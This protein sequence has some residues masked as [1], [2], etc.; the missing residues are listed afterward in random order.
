MPYW[1]SQVI[2]VLCSLALH[3]VDSSSPWIIKDRIPREYNHHQLFPICYK[4]TSWLH[5]ELITALWEWANWKRP[6]VGWFVVT[7]CCGEWKWIELLKSASAVKRNVSLC[8]CS[9]IWMTSWNWGGCMRH[10]SL[11]LKNAFQS[12]HLYINYA[13][14]TALF[15][16]SCWDALEHSLLFTFCS[17]A[18]A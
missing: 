15:P 8:V 16:L 3:L 13:R 18:L 4:W 14:K 7:S 2:W 5:F 11:S 1:G 17:F 9:G 10:N 6:N 12:M